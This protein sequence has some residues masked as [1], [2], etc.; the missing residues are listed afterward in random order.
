MTYR[1]G[2]VLMLLAALAASGCRQSDGIPPQPSGEQVNKTEDVSRDLLNVAARQP[3][4]AN[5][6][7]ADLANLSPAPPPPDLVATLAQNLQDAIG[8]VALSEAAAL[9]LANRLFVATTARELSARQV[10]RLRQD[11]SATLTQ[12]GVPPQK[13]EA[14]GGRI[15]EIQDAITTNRARWWHLR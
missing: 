4:A 10:E 11:V 12:A 7:Q 5:D 3:G 15:G 2:R 1:F 6:L 13:A 9:E 8:G 14:V